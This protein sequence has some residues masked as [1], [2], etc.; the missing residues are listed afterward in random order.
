MKKNQNKQK[1][2]V[3]GGTGFIGKRVVK[4]LLERGKKVNLLV[5]DKISV[6]LKNE[7]IKIFKGDLS[8]KKTIVK[9]VKSSDIV[10]NLVGTFNEDIF[11]LLNIVSSANL[12]DACKEAKNIKKIIFVSSEAVYGNY[13]GRPHNENDKPEPAT[14]YGFSKYLA[15]ETYKFYSKRYKI[16]VII[17]RLANTYGPGHRIGV[18]SECLD[19][20]L[21]KRP[22]RI[23]KDGRQ[24]RDFLYVDDAAEGIVKSLVCKTDGVSVFNITGQKAYSLIDT[25]K[26]IERIIGKKIKIN[27]L[28]KKKQDI[29]FI[30]WGQYMP[31]IR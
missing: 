25:L 21:H 12:L 29:K 2:L 18:I 19:S 1:I 11:Y 9:A 31:K 13:K 22:V 3:C 14:E 28:P 27:F 4:K 20:I 6:S 24:K 23:H 17:L 10:L 8:D 30:I 5:Y 7:N 26:I 16:P 15:E